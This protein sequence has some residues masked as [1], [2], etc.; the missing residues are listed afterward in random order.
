L[1]IISHRVHARRNQLHALVDD[2]LRQKGRRGRA[3]AG[4]VVGL[5]RHCA[6]HLGAHVLELVVELDLL[7]DCDAV[8]GDAR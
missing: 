3:V 7:G 2:R 6:H 8:L 1:A 4:N 5:G